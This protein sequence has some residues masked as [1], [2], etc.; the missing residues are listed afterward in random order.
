MAGGADQN[1]IA[2]SGPARHILG[3]YLPGGTGLVVHDESLAGFGLQVRRELAGQ[4]I[5]HA[6]RGVGHHERD[7]PGGV[8]V[9]RVYR[10]GG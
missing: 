1:G 3:R 2:V 4:D 8:A 6:A 9:C 10:G 7:R 5:R